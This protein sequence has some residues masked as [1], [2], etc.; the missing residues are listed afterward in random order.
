MS[1]LTLNP[2]INKK[3][4]RIT[5][6]DEVFATVETKFAVF[7]EDGILKNYVKGNFIVPPASGIMF[8]DSVIQIG[9]ENVQEAIEVLS[10]KIDSF[11]WGL[12]EW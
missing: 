5:E 7:D 3:G 2:N 8:D 11:S 10:N 4:V 9:V 1:V 12:Q 6:F